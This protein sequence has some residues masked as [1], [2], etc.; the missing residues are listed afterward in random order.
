MNVLN[1]LLVGISVVLFAALVVLILV[2]AVLITW[3]QV[4]E[5][6]KGSV[7]HENAER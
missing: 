4:N 3:M 7:C 6:Q 1:A 5:E 2:A